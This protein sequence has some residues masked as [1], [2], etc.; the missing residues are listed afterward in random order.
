MNKLTAKIAASS[1]FV[2]AL[3][4]PFA[5]PAYAQTGGPSGT[6]GA[7]ATTTDTTNHTNYWG[8]LGL[9]GLAG[10]AGLRRRPS[11]SA[12]SRSIVR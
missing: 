10:L 1:A 5:A 8:L 6:S 2:V 4:L 3:L 9:L 12:D 11:E 7:G